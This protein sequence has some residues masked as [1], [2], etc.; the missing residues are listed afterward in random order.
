[1]K[2]KGLGIRMDHRNIQF[3]DF[4]KN[5]YKLLFSEEESSWA[6]GM[7]LYFGEEVHSS[8]ILE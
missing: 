1:M 8:T 7:G 2:N 4:F 6:V 3:H 5:S